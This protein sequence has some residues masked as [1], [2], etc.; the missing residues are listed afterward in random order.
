MIVVLVVAFVCGTVYFLIAAS[1]GVSRIVDKD[2]YAHGLD[3]EKGEARFVAGARL[4]W[5]AST[6]IYGDALVIL[7][8]DSTGSPVKGGVLTFIIDRDMSGGSDG[9]GSSP[10]CASLAAREERPGSYRA[11]LPRES[12]NELKGRVLFTKGDA[13]LVERMV[14]VR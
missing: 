13:A 2:Y 9:S 5:R 12:G 4:G 8:N 11:T 3:Y 1:R 14:I 6:A 10:A 7:V